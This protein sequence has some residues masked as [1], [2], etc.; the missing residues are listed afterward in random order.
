MPVTGT[1]YTLTK[2]AVEA[3]LTGEISTHTHAI[4]TPIV[5]LTQAA[6]DAITPDPSTLYIITS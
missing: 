2:A 6:Y 5:A 1:V 4:D 3:V